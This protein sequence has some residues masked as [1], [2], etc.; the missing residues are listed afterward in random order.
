[1][2]E[3]HEILEENIEYAEHGHASL[4]MPVTVTLS[5]LAVLIAIATLLG[6]RTSKEEIL[7]QAQ[8]ADQ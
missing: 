2:S 8:E 6:Q 1:M 5:I 3:A 4:S 7:L